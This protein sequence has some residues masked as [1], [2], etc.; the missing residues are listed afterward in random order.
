LR[1][2]GADVTMFTLTEGSI[3]DLKDADIIV[4]GAGQPHFIKP[5]HIREGVVLIDAGASESDDTI[6]GDADPACARLSR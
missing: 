2:L 1:E 4:S 3:A 6:Q 5:E